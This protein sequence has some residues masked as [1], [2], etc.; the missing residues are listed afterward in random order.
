MS[1]NPKDESPDSHQAD[2]ANPVKTPR[3]LLLEMA[4][5][6]WPMDNA[7]QA[8]GLDD[9]EVEAIP[10]VENVLPFE[11]AEKRAGTATVTFFTSRPRSLMSIHEPGPAPN[12]PRFPEEESEEELLA[13]AKRHF[14]SIRR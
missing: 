9:E 2:E 7:E 12:L 11:N 8:D 10:E 14:G 4:Q 13:H 5:C 6:R 3:E 1:N